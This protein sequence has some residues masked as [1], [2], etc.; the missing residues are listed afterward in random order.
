MKRFF[1]TSCSLWALTAM[2]QSVEIPAFSSCAEADFVEVEASE[3]DV[4]FSGAD[5]LPK[6]LKIKSNTT[7]TLPASGRHPL[8]ASRDFDGV[9]N[10]FLGPEEGHMSAQTH[11]LTEAG[12][13]G[14][15]CTRHGNAQDGGAMSGL[16][17]VVSP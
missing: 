4:A 16:I 3:V 1:I 9:P 2:A 13:Y 6:C 12:F 8:Q 5:Y 15:Y 7:V 17:W 14:Y 10:P 11:T